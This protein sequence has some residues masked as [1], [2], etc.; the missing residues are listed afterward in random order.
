[1]GRFWSMEVANTA[2]TPL[3]S[4]KNLCFAS[5]RKIRGKTDTFTNINIKYL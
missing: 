5:D 1:M 4:E 2:G 3:T